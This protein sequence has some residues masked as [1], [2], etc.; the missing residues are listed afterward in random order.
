VSMFSLQQVFSIR[1]KV[2][3]SRK[4]VLKLH[5]SRLIFAPS[6]LLPCIDARVVRLP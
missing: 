3:H 4:R 1:A 5:R 6:P 2:S